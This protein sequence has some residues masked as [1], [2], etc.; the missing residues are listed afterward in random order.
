MRFSPGGQRRRR[1]WLSQSESHKEN[2]YSWPLSAP[3]N[4]T[5]KEKPRK[6]NERRE[7]FSC[8]VGPTRKREQN[9]TPISRNV[10]VDSRKALYKSRFLSPSFNLI[11]NHHRS[12]IIVFLFFTQ[13]DLS[14]SLSLCVLFS[15]Q[16]FVCQVRSLLL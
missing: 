3:K 8:Q 15:P 10:Q 13:N 1:C 2:L 11:Q 4:K 14:L 5:K 9:L 7:K 16:L 6:I 12:S